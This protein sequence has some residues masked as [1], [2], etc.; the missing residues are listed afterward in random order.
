MTKEKVKV[1]VSQGITITGVI[2]N[3]LDTSRFVNMIVC[4]Q[5]PSEFI[6]DG[7]PMP[8]NLFFINQITIS[9][10]Y[11]I[12][13]NEFGFTKLD[14]KQSIQK[15]IEGLNIQKIDRDDKTISYEPIVKKTNDEVVNKK[16]E[17][18]R[19]GAS[20]VIIIAGFLKERINIVHVK[21][22]GF[23]ETCKRLGMNI[24]QTPKIDFDKEKS[25]KEN[26]K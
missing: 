8:P 10:T 11:G 1:F 2:K 15:W 26:L 4:F 9:E 5:E 20:D 17:K 19:I 7:I 12:L 3:G 14:A 18:Y 16:G 13:L 21:D 22:K 6:V 24:I 25:I 23:E